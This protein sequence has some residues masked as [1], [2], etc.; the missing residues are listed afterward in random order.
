MGKKKINVSGADLKRFSLC[1]YGFWINYRV[2]QNT[3]QCLAIEVLLIFGWLPDMKLR[4]SV[5]PPIHSF[6]H[7]FYL[8]SRTHPSV[9]HRFITD[10]N[11]NV[12]PTRSDNLSLNY[13]IVHRYEAPVQ[14]RSRR[15][16]T[17]DQQL[18]LGLV[19]FDVRQC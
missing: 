11:Q 2:Q 4:P 9:F 12:Q 19:L 18:K 5:H 13:F 7:P 3:D 10:R 14:G 8:H 6:I 15:S 16:Q 17:K 1:P